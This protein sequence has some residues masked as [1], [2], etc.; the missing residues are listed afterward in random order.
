MIYCDTD[1]VLRYDINFSCIGV[2]RYIVTPLVNTEDC[3]FVSAFS[4][5]PNPFIVLD[6]GIFSALEKVFT[7][8][9]NRQ[10]GEHARVL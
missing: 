7:M 1:F 10:E 4:L 8:E 6:I 9:N 2:Y 5:L 3:P